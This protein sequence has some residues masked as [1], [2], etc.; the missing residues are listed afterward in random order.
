MST[1]N[2][3]VVKNES[4]DQ[5]KDEV[6]DSIKVLISYFKTKDVTK[7]SNKIN[8]PLYRAYPIPPILNKS[9]FN[10]RFNEVF[11]ETLIHQIVHSKINQWEEVGWRGIMLNNGDLWMANLDG[12]ISCIN[13]QSEFEKQYRTRLIELDKQHLHPSLKTFHNPIYKIKTTQYLIR[14]DEL[15]DYNYRY[16]SWKNN[17]NEKSNPDIVINNGNWE[18][19]GSGGNHVITFKNGIYTY[20]VYRNFL[21][22]ENT[23][24][25]TIEIDKDG[26][27]VS[28]MDGRLIR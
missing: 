12:V 6:I 25:V 18:N 14:I 19:L 20:K 9:E 21:G 5:L 1:L 3:G 26:K 8:Y 2:K 22:T 4:T 10:K 7:I 27:T 23:P 24:D 16:A 11:D 28:K 17:Q 13:Y 15:D